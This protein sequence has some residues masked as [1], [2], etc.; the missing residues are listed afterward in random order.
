MR[1]VFQRV[2]VRVWGRTVIDA[3]D[4]DY[5]NKL[6][7]VFSRKPCF[8]NIEAHHDVRTPLNKTIIMET[9]VWRITSTNCSVWSEE[10]YFETDNGP[11]ICHAC[12]STL[13][14]LKNEHKSDQLVANQE[15]KTPC[16]INVPSNLE[17]MRHDEGELSQ[18]HSTNGEDNFENNDFKIEEDFIDDEPRSK[19]ETKIS[20]K[21]RIGASAR[22][23]KRYQN[24]RRMLET[25]KKEECD[26][27]LSERVKKIS[28]GSGKKLAR[29]KRVQNGPIQY[30]CPICN[31]PV[32]EEKEGFWSHLRSVHEQESV[33]CDFASCSYACVGY[34]PM[35]AHKMEDHSEDPSVVAFMGENNE[36]KCTCDICG[37]NL[38][39]KQLSSHYRINHP[40]ALHGC[41]FLCG[42]CGVAFDKRNSRTHHI[43]KVHLQGSYTCDDC[44]KEFNQLQYLRNHQKQVHIK[45]KKQCP[46][47]KDWFNAKD[48]LAKHIRIVHTGEKPFKCT[49]CEKSFFDSLGAYTHKKCHHPD[50]YSVYQKRKVWLRDNPE[51]DPSEYKVECHLCDTFR[52]NDLND[53]RRHWNDV[54]PNQADIP[55]RGKKYQRKIMC[56]I[57]GA[58]LPN[59]TVL[60]IHT[61]KVHELEEKKCPICSNQFQSREEA[62]NHVDGAHKTTFPS[63]LKDSVCEHCGYRSTSSQVKL[64]KRIHASN[65]I[66]P[67]SCTYCQKEFPSFKNMTHH[68]R[69]AHR[70]QWKADRERLMAQEG[71]LLSTHPHRKVR[72]KEERRATCDVCGTTLSSRAQ[73]HLHM[74][75]RH[76]TGLP[77]YK[78]GLS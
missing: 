51:M 78:E 15:V 54:H 19:T 36:Q 43:D 68:R 45:E 69:L 16:D 3:Q 47:C 76:G 6:E 32:A 8:G 23:R 17:N 53:L 38:I 46:H 24:D 13:S 67:K 65:V 74:K 7:M 56:D 26:L 48:G 1:F 40:L 57:C 27:A 20:Q 10:G 5:A 11:A 37:K 2:V 25:L 60:K 77:G 66:R 33:E 14:I 64:H 49:F 61:F 30:K 22:S 63:Q 42:Y 9:P 12:K 21:R 58:T 70:E 52:S 62:L 75:A 29:R 44:G 18:P 4:G 41:Q 34:Q 50:S 73:L 35:V 59:S 55:I 71:S 28:V 31:V 72:T 39:W